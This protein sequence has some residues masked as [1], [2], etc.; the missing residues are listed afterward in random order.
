MGILNLVEGLLI[1]VGMGDWNAIILVI[2]ILAA[3]YVIV[4]MIRRAKAQHDAA[5]AAIRDS[6]RIAAR[7]YHDSAWN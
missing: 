5:R 3:A 6:L 4:L 2:C 1:R 7:R